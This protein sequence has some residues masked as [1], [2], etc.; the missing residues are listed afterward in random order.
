MVIKNLCILLF[1]KKV[2]SALE[3]LR[4]PIENV[5][6]IY[7]IFNNRFGIRNDFPKHLNVSE[8]LVVF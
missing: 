7:N 3:R 6:H 2:A 5:V 1:W 8:W 4:V